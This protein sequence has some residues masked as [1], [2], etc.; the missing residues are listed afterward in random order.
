MWSIA[1]AL[2]H[3]SWKTLSISWVKSRQR[4]WNE[5]RNDDD[6]D[7]AAHDKLAKWQSKS[8]RKTVPQKIL[9]VYKYLSHEYTWLFCLQ[10]KFMLSLLQVICLFDNYFPH[11]VAKKILIPRIFLANFLSI[12]LYGCRVPVCRQY[13]RRKLPFITDESSGA[14]ENRKKLALQE[15]ICFI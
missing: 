14:R 1:P 4:M 5:E 8:S 10:W 2:L 9:N 13:W 6:L 7:S 12:C 15:L 11:S 3:A